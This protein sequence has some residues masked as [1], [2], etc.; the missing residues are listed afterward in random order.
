M[1]AC[2]ARMSHMGNQLRRCIPDGWLK[3]CHICG[4]QVLL[5]TIDTRMHSALWLHSFLLKALHRLSHLQDTPL[6][7]LRGALGPARLCIGP[8]MAYH[9]HKIRLCPLFLASGLCGGLFSAC[10]RT[11]APS[12]IWFWPFA[13]RPLMAFPPQA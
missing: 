7:G 9:I 8:C 1:S 13:A 10:L 12:R 3:A 2:S 11:C 4:T 6:Q 5:S